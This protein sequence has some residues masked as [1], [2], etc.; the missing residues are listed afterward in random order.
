MVIGVLALQGAFIE[1]EKVLKSLG[2]ECFEIR[3]KKD[4]ERHMDGL[5]LPG[6]ESTVMGKLMV[7]LDLFEN[8]K[9]QILNGLPV[10]GTC[11]G[12]ILLAQNLS[13]DTKKYFGTLPVTVKRNAYGR[14]LGSF[15]KEEEMKYVGKIPMTFIRAPYIE[16]VRGDVEVLA[17]VDGNI[18]AVRYGNQLGIS[19][20]PEVTQNSAVHAYFLKMCRQKQNALKTLSGIG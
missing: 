8:L 4:L 9:E 16:S 19:F 3:Q 7:E 11:A 1:H 5:V 2:A 15:S 6:G 14:Q 13:N 18:V 17:K 10:F 20:H 12:L